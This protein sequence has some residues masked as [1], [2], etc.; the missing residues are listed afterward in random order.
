MAR[1]RTRRP[2]FG[3][4]QGPRESAWS[5][6]ARDLEQ[7]KALANENENED[8]GEGE[9]DEEAERDPGEGDE[10]SKALTLV[11]KRLPKAKA[12]KTETGLA[13]VAYKSARDSVAHG[14]KELDWPKIM[15][16]GSVALVGAWAAWQLRQKYKAPE[17]TPEIIDMERVMASRQKL[18]TPAGQMAKLGDIV[19]VD[20][21]TLRALV[22]G[23]PPDARVIRMRVRSAAPRTGPLPPNVLVTPED[24]AWALGATLSPLPVPRTAI[25]QVLATTQVTRA[26]NDSFPPTVQNLTPEAP[27]PVPPPPQQQAPASGV[28]YLGNPLVPEPGVT[29]RARLQLTG[30]EATF[31]S[32]SLIA[33][34]FNELGFVNISVWKRSAELPPDWPEQERG[35]EGSGR[36]FL[37]GT[38]GQEPRVVDRPS[39]IISTWVA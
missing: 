31:A 8:E 25:V 37:Q 18:D 17:Q 12:A 20:A 2:G 26:S 5:R 22:A 33:A 4:P 35:P 36:Y 7:E 10:A 32:P 6:W 34:K 11:S 16:M 21:V 14:L 24:P 9:V 30:L 13:T 38:W 23:V 27:A 29:Y 28:R 15:V 3:S 39:Q 19:L 1:T